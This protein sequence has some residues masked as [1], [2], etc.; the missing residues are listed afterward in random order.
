MDTN[1]LRSLVTLFGLALFVALAVWTWRPA[2]RAEHDR[3]A[4]LPLIGEAG[5]GTPGER[6]E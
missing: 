6:D 1:D 2:R 3:A 5:F 4:Q